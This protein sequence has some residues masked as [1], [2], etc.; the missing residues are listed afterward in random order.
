MT[1]KANPDAPSTGGRERRS[2]ARIPVI[3]WVEE[4]SSEGQVFRRAGNLSRGGLHLDRTIPIAVG[5][6]VQ[7]RFCL[8]E[9]EGG[10]PLLVTG[11]VVSIDPSRDL[12]MGVKFVEV[13]AAVQ[14]RL[15]GYLHRALTPLEIVTGR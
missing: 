8:P 4:I 14:S 6:S 3:M 12:G 7:L 2:S 9:D 15:D 1:Q 5:S 13:P 11:V 10:E